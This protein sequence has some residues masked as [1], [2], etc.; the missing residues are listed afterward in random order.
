LKEIVT[1]KEEKEGETALRMMEKKV[2]EGGGEEE[3][4]AILRASGT[5]VAPFDNRGKR[6]KTLGEK[7]SVVERFKLSQTVKKN[8][9]S[10]V[11]VSGKKDGVKTLEGGEGEK[12]SDHNWTKKTKGDW[13]V[14]RQKC[15]QGGVVVRKGEQEW[16]IV[17]QEKRE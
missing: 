4:P 14:R 7:R 15:R 16:R 9:E 13:K 11:C 10:G 17:N 8:G 3:G 12:Q 1:K 6:K 2:L 5:G